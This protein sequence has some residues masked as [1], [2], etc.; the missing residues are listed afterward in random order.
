MRRLVV[1]L[2]LGGAMLA[3]PPAAAQAPS[4]DAATLSATCQANAADDMQLATCEWVVSTVLAPDP[5]ASPSAY[6]SELPGVGV[7]LARDDQTVT[8]AEVRWDVKDAFGAKPQTKGDRYVAVRVEYEGIEDG[9]S[10]NPLLWSAVD[11]DGFAWNQSFAGM[12]PALQSSNDLPA[13]RKAQGWI[14]F[15]VP[16]SVHALEIVESQSDYLRWLVT[17]PE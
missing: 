17:E 9:T 6:G 12:A 3:G 15:E 16:K 7:T 14:T 4:L 13:G 2:V 8:L 11:L 1:G 5:A 10:Y